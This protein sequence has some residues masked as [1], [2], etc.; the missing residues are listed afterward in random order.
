MTRYALGCAFN[1]EEILM[2]LPYK[3][4]KLRCKDCYDLIKDNHRN[5]LAAR[6]FRV[7]LK[8][9][10]ED[11]I[12]NNITFWFP[13]TGNRKCNLHMK[14]VT[15]QDF[16]NLR[17]GGKWQ[18][19]DIINSMFTGYEIKLFMLGNRT[20]RV[21]SVYLNRQ[22]R[23][24]ITL[25]TNQGMTYG[26]SKYDKILKDYYEQIYSIFPEVPKT[27]IQKILVFAWKSLYLHNSYGGDTLVQG[28]KF[29][30]YIGSLKKNPLDHFYYYK[31]KLITKL[32]VLYKRK[33]VE[34]DGY[35]YFALSDKQYQS[36]LSQK[37]KRGRP[38][39]HFDFGPVYLY[40]ILDECKI[41]EHYSKYIFRVPYIS[42]VKVKWFSYNFSST[43]AELVTIREPL[44]FKDILINDNEYTFL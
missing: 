22:Y 9:V 6:I 10:I 15:G 42:P 19:V 40:Q 32:R 38:R 27:D 31:R 23:D 43:N 13:L 39:K 16:K 11:I 2:N 12:Q 17:K 21:K 41:S 1:T 8:L 3:K 24:Q 34:W 14:G 44:K 37:K 30:C 28:D 33:K 25:K 18:G 26:D 7:S 20:P 29:W 36:Y 5:K 35:Y 4:L